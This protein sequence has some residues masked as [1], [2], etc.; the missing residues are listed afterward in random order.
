LLRNHP[1]ALTTG[2]VLIPPPNAAFGVISDIDDTIVR[3]GAT[4]LLT[5]ARV[6]LL[7]N[8]HT[9]LP[10]QGIAA[11][12]AALERGPSGRGR[13]PL[14]YVSSGPW[15]L[16][17]VLVQFLALNRIPA[18]P[19]FLQ[20]WGLGQRTFIKTGHREHKLAVIGTL[21]AD[22][23]QLPFVLVGDSGEEDAAIY[24][25]VVRDHP[26]RI[27]AIYIRDTALEHRATA[28]RAI[29]EELRA[30]PTPLLLASDTFAAAKHAVAHGLIHPDAL[31]AI[32]ADKARDLPPAPLAAWRRLLAG[33]RRGLRR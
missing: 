12:Y 32:R 13:N 4:S 25:E 10:F 6:V 5:M 8:A 21:L 14:F 3:T 11:F 29:A 31:G 1:A 24:R 28:V 15:N 26:G 22:Y 2:D 23:P 17:D 7:S 20:D 19:L 33:V 16:Y 9:R 30:G 18:G 27:R